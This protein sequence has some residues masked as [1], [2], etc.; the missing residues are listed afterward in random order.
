[1]EREECRKAVCQDRTLQYR[2]IRKPVK[3]IN[4]RICPDG[5]ILVSAHPS[6]PAGRI[7][8]FVIEKQDFILRALESYE[9]KRK[10]SA[11]LPRQSHR[12]EIFREICGEIYPLFGAY[13]V[14]Y[15]QIKM[16]AMTSCWGV[17]HPKKG[18]I[19]L[20]R[21]LLSVPR[22]C[23]EYVVLHELAHFVHPNH[24]RQFYDLLTVLMPDWR[25]RKKELEN[26]AYR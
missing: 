2:L 10:L 16:R 15:P 9:E 4:L 19:T 1:M 18:S 3:H 5:R 12:E 25:M 23:I 26:Y 6:V 14:P 7:D 20:N 21:R 11:L 24:S 22:S 8:A 13:P 17:C